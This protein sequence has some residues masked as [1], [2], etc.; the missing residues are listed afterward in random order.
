MSTR[1]PHLLLARH[2]FTLIE[3]L[4]V[5]SILSLLVA[6][7]LPA[8]A[9]AR[10]TAMR[11]A[12]QSNLRQYGAAIVIYG[13]D[14]DQ[15]ILPN[16][17]RHPNSASSGYFHNWGLILSVY[18]DS[19]YGSLSDPGWATL[20][21]HSAL[22]AI[23]GT[24]HACPAEQYPRGTVD[25]V[26][27]ITPEAAG[28]VAYPPRSNRAGRWSYTQ[29]AI[30][31]YA[32]RRNNPTYLPGDVDRITWN[33]GNL[34]ETNLPKIDQKAYPSALWMVGE[35]LPGDRDMR[36]DATSLNSPALYSYKLN[37]ERHP[38]S[39]NVVHLDGHIDNIHPTDPRG[40][41]VA[42]TTAN[43]ATVRNYQHWGVYNNS[44][45]GW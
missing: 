45:A 26:T 8:L 7:L 11:L 40:A 5:I 32:T 18:L 3:L 34:D 6:L 25:S 2:A 14:H 19:A 22:D 31:T 27:A 30:N 20:S 42:D 9:G 4:V 43:E 41:V 13:T 15:Y 39:M 10:D 37:F 16:R 29:Y 24:V 38:F 44:N 12:C 17:Y 23:P 28:T 1:S 21:S 35:A 33:F 36:M